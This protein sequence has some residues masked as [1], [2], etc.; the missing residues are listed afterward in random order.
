M[1]EPYIQRVLTEAKFVLNASP[2]TIFRIFRA[3]GWNG[4]T[5]TMFREAIEI[6]CDRGE[7]MKLG[8]ASAIGFVEKGLARKSIIYALPDNTVV[9]KPVVVLPKAPPKYQPDVFATVLHKGPTVFKRETHE[10]VMQL[11]MMTR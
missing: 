3:S 7:L 1:N 6:L 9:R 5:Y 11:R 10:D 4:S 8:T 2:N